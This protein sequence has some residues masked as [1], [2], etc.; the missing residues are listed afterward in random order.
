MQ[1]LFK[2]W[3]KY[4]DTC[5]WLE[6]CLRFSQ[7]SLIKQLTPASSQVRGVPGPRDV[8][9]LLLLRPAGQLQRPHQAGWPEGLCQKG[10]LALRIWVWLLKVRQKAQ[11]D[12]CIFWLEWLCQKSFSSN[13][14]GLP[15]R[16]GKKDAKREIFLVEFMVWHS[17][18]IPNESFGSLSP[19][20]SGH[21]GIRCTGFIARDGPQTGCF[22]WHFRRG[23]TLTLHAFNLHFFHYFPGPT[24]RWSDTGFQ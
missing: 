6:K 18:G 8:R 23:T 1:G 19:K 7:R 3:G 21:P 9:L 14:L 24:R 4:V 22:Q 5:T 11:D 17:F 12:M 2:T 15:W 16:F 20:L 10:N 13:N